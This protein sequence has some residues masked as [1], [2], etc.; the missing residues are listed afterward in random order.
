VVESG[1]VVEVSRSADS[2]ASMAASSKSPMRLEARL[3]SAN[4]VMLRRFFFFLFGVGF[5]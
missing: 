3:M 4:S 5:G 1:M 2:M